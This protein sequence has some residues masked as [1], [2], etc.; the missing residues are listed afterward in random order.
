MDVQVH[1][2]TC[3]HASTLP[4]IYKM[5]VW[6]FRTRT[7]FLGHIFIDAGSGSRL[8]RLRRTILLLFEDKSLKAG[9]FQSLIVKTGS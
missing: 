4:F 5:W 1:M 2:D 8:L 9:C 6:V 3:E 7:P